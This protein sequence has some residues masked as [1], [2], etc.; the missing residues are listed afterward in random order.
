[1][2]KQHLRDLLQV[3]LTIRQTPYVKTLFSK[4][5]KIGRWCV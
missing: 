5:N 2:I 3:R 1:M 4:L